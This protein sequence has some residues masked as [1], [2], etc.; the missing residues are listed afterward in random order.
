MGGVGGRKRAVLLEPLGR[1]SLGRFLE[2]RNE[3]NETGCCISSE[4]RMKFSASLCP[5][6]TRPLYNDELVAST[7]LGE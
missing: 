2:E 3:M 4:C 5:A 1:N 7:C 6:I